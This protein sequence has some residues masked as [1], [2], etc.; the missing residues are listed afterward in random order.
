VRQLDGAGPEEIV[1][2]GSQTPKGGCLR[3][4]A[5]RNFCSSGIW[6]AASIIRIVGLKIVSESISMMS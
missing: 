5:F 3:Q 6:N 1:P 4:P 2:S